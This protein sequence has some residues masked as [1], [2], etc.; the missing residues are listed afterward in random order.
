M[1]TT[2]TDVETLFQ[3]ISTLNQR[4]VFAGFFLGFKVGKDDFLEQSDAFFIIGQR[5]GG[6]V[7]SKQ[8][9]NHTWVYYA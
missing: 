9:G 5:F 4:W 1:D 7:T 6:K 8:L 2:L 3:H